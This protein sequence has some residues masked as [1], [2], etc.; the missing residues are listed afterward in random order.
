[1]IRSVIID[2]EAGSVELIS[3]LVKLTSPGL[4]VTA[5]AGS[6]ESGYTT[7]LKH[8]PAIVF[9]DVQMRDG[10]GFD[11]L[12]K[13]EAIDFKVVFI[14]AFH[15]HAIT[16]FKFSAVDYLL[17]PVS[18]KDFKLAVQKAEKAITREE[19]SLRFESLLH[20]INNPVPDKKKLTLKTID[21]LY[22]VQ[23]DEI[24]RFEA[25]GSYTHVFLK[26]GRKIMVSR[27]IKEFEELLTGS[28][29]V[30]IHQSHLVNTSEIFYF[31]KTTNKLIMKDKTTIPVSTRK[32]E[33]LF[34][35]IET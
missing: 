24:L 21:R 27:L 5:T 34:T 32:R 22:S 1:V 31:E 17:K 9:L 8:K 28:S 7:I 23:L 13:F 26:D 10:N 25:E 4:E 29:F 30:R 11:L 3:N 35:L 33:L 19:I 16:A 12:R 20:N 14:T 2:D 15:E 18:L 6:V